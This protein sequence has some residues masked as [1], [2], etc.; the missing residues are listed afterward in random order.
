MSD[1]KSGSNIDIPLTVVS[2][3]FIMAIGCMLAL[4]PEQSTELADTI[5]WGMLRGLGSVYLWLGLAAVVICVGISFS[6][7]GNIRLG[8]NK[9]KFTI[10]QYFA[11]M[12][13]AGLGA[14]TLYWGFLEVIYYY[15]GPPFGLKPESVTAAE[16][17]LTV[18]MNHYG[19]VP[20]GFYAVASLPL[21]YT[22]YIKKNRQLR[23]STV[24][25]L[26][27]GPKIVNAFVQ[28]TIDFL[29]VIV[30]IGALTITIGLAIPVITNAIVN[31]TGIKPSIL[32]DIG[33][34]LFIALVF[35]ISSAI[36][37]EKGLNRMSSANILMALGLMAFIFILGPTSFIMANTTS[38]L[39]QYLQNFITLSTW[40]DPIKNGSFPQLWTIFY[41][42]FWLAYTPPM[43]LFITRISRGQR[44]KDV[45]LITMVGGTLG[46]SLFLGTFGSYSLDAQLTGL[47]NCA[48]FMH[49]NDSA[50][51]IWALLT[52]LPLPM[53]CVSIYI[54]SSILFM[55]TT[56]DGF[57]FSIA[58]VT[59]REL[60]LNDNPSTKFRLFWCIVLTFLPL[61]MIYIDA[62]LNTLKTVA[63]LVGTPFVIIFSVMV[64]GVL[65]WMNQDFSKMSST[66]IISYNNSLS[67]STDKKID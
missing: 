59:T 53:V 48:S 54:L 29:T 21:C 26:A 12:A 13:S 38:S 35:T 64:F 6:K 4:F 2:V 22:F 8:T 23:L 32:I 51:L 3:A 30:A 46:C 66:E 43:V 36:G 44:I 20:W 49:A 9:P 37:I 56:M 61:I 28:K 42:A 33:T 52:S 27:L 50:G 34:V 7:F 11:M 10:F 39:G 40:M 17:A 16:W 5:F 60:D 24:C 57:S 67:D 25:E 18:N 15:V 63:L 45:L 31:M 19:F 47:V 14:A 62:P 41:W 1:K 55:A 65:K 58:S